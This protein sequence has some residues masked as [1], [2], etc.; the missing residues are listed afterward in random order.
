MHTESYLGCIT[1]WTKQP[2]ISTL[3]AGTMSLKQN[4]WFSLKKIYIFFK[5][6]GGT[7][8]GMNHEN[9]TNSASSL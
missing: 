6:A 9:K 1:D 7:L 5:H 2:N 4:C 8:E 3:H